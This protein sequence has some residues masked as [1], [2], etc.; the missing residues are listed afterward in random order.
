[1]HHAAMLRQRPPRRHRSAANGAAGVGNFGFRLQPGTRNVKPR[2]K[3]AAQLNIPG[4][5]RT[6]PDPFAIYTA[7]MAVGAPSAVT[8]FS[9]SAQIRTSAVCPPNALSIRL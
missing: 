7:R 9:L 8:R 2:Q 5:E 3:K 1:M 4:F 6:F